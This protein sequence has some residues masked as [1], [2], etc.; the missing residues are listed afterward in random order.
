MK[1]YGECCA[2][3]YEGLA[4]ENEEGNTIGSREESSDNKA[5]TLER[6][7]KKC[8]WKSKE[9]DVHGMSEVR[10]E[11]QFLVGGDHPGK[12]CHCWKPAGC[13]EKAEIRGEP[14]KWCGFGLFV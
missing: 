4:S 2:G 6:C 1:K 7:D 14:A 12:W 11:S 10:K 5:S 13:G 3:N 9:S 8:G